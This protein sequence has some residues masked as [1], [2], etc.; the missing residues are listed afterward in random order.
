MIYS[1]LARPYH[2]YPNRNWVPLRAYQNGISVEIDR[3]WSHRKSAPDFLS[4]FLAGKIFFFLYLW[5]KSICHVR[6]TSDDVFFSKRLVCASFRCKTSSTGKSENHQKSR[7][8]RANTFAILLSGN[9]VALSRKIPKATTDVCDEW[10]VAQRFNMGGDS[11]DE[12]F[13]NTQNRLIMI[14]FQPNFTRRVD[15]IT[16]KRRD[17]ERKIVSL[18]GLVLT[19]NL[20]HSPDSSSRRTFLVSFFPKQKFIPQNSMFADKRVFCDQ[21]SPPSHLLSIAPTEKLFFLRLIFVN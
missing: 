18:R 12:T 8:K 3:R 19:I 7:E 13:V 4:R 21:T 1:L 17:K 9:F 16:G 10:W 5:L 20:F 2:T 11:K 15:A 6:E 14:F